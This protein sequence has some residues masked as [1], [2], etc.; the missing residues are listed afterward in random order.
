ML[1]IPQLK[2]K[3][4]EIRIDLIKMLFKAGSGRALTPIKQLEA[5]E[6]D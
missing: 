4:K 6:K 1:D 3:A 5:P 2:L